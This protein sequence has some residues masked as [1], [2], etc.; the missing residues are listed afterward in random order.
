M[1]MLVNDLSEV[2]GSGRTRRVKSLVIG[3]TRTQ[4]QFKKECDI[5]VVVS[6][7][8]KTGQLPPPKAQGF[9]ADV[10]DVEDFQSAREAVR[11]AEADFMR[12]PAAIRAAFDNDPTVFVDAFNDPD[13]IDTLVEMGLLVRTQD[14]NQEADPL[15]PGEPS[16][17]PADP[18]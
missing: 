5:N 9:Y 10:S 8:M 1:G 17:P 7:F 4:Q 11:Q 13:N 2:S 16:D 6:R 14:G 3:E 18:D 15:P 12:Y